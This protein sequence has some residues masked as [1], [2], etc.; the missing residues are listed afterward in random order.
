MDEPINK[1]AQYMSVIDNHGKCILI[2]MNDI[3]RI[4][5]AEYVKL[6]DRKGDYQ[7]CFIDWKIPYDIQW[8]VFIDNDNTKIWNKFQKV[9][10][11]H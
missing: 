5:F 2:D 11:N 3:A 4:N 6:P 8:Q 7:V 1:D 10:E 9:E